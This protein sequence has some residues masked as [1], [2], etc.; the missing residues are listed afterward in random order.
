MAIEKDTAFKY[1]GKDFMNILL[2]FSKLPSDINLNDLE[3]VTLEM[4]NLKI[5]QWRPDLILRNSSVILMYEFES[6]YLSEKTK[7]RFL[8]YLSLYNQQYNKD[9]LDIYFTVITNKGK[10][11]IIPYKIDGTLQFNIKVININDLGFSET[12]NSA[13]TKIKN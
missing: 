7:K 12:I 9:N 8:A 5:S 10:T 3:E 13:K 4:E 6:S 11:Q 2:E 1:I